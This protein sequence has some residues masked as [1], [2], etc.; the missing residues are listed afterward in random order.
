M[1]TDEADRL[2]SAEKD[3]FL[4]LFVLYRLSWIEDYWI[5]VQNNEVT[6]GMVIWVIYSAAGTSF[7]RSNLHNEGYNAGIENLLAWH[8]N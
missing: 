7:K 8:H 3:F 2:A 6:V 1:E 5:Q 4:V